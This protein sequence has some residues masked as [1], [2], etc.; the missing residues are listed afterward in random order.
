M[1]SATRK[2]IIKGFFDKASEEVTGLG[3]GMNTGFHSAIAFIWCWI[4]FDAF[5]T[6][7]Y[8]EES[9][10]K[11]VT[12]FTSSYA[13]D[14]SQ[15]YDSMPDEFKR[16]MVGL[17]QYGIQNMNPSHLI[18]PPIRIQD[19]KNLGQVLDV[20][21]RIRNNLFHGGKDMNEEK[22]MNLVVYASK[23]LYYILEKFL[24]KEGLI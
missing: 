12:N 24:T 15:D 13:R 5:A 3:S 21:Y 11:R 7:K 1:V 22:D 14:Y 17:M 8:N 2:E 20:I 6:V 19:S 16:N 18:D 10:R 4:S 23:V 9:P